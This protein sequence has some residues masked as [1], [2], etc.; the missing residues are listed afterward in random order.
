MKDTSAWY[1]ISVLR[2]TKIRA[3]RARYLQ[4]TPASEARCAHP[5]IFTHGWGASIGGSGWHG[6]GSGHLRASRVVGCFPVSCPHDMARLHQDPA[7]TNLGRSVATA[8]G[9]WAPGRQATTGAEIRP[10]SRQVTG[11]ATGD[12]G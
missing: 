8:T 7:T 12:N 3:A 2:T 5:R 4:Y 6:N 1:Q 9:F 10:S 11:S